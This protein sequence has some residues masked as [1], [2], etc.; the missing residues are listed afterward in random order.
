VWN[1]GF[2]THAEG[3]DLALLDPTPDSEG[4]QTQS[5]GCYTYSHGRLF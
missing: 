4:M 2:I 5:A 1:T 3:V